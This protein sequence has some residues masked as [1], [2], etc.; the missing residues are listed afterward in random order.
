M[1]FSYSD[2]AIL[3]SNNSVELSDISTVKV[4]SP[5]DIFAKPGEF[6][7]D[8]A[9]TIKQIGDDVYFL[10]P[11]HTFRFSTKIGCFFLKNDKKFLDKT[12]DYIEKQYMTDP[13]TRRH[14][15]GSSKVVVDKYIIFMNGYDSSSSSG[16]TSSNTLRSIVAYDTETGE[17]AMIGEGKN[18]TDVDGTIDKKY[19]AYSYYKDGYIYT[20][21]GNNF[22]DEIQ[23]DG[24][25]VKGKCARLGHI[26]RYDLLTGEIILLNGETAPGVTKVVRTISDDLVRTETD[27]NGLSVINSF[28]L[29]SF[30]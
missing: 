7:R 3:S 13:Y 15:A 22:F 16:P 29:K 24:S 14:I 19:N 21:S 10:T 9:H 11:T 5:Y 26:E 20:F 28:V 25:I 23:A 12:D 18:D 4:R 2:G 1:I 17:F 30:K 8:G 6:S 27:S